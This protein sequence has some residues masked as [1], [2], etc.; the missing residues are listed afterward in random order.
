M[1]LLNT[2]IMVFFISILSTTNVGVCSQTSEQRI[3]VAD[4]HLI[5][6]QSDAE[7]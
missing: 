2:T 3:C 6:Q 7:W 5:F 4:I 1:R